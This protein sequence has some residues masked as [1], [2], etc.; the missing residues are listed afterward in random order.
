[1]IDLNNLMD[2]F[3]YYFKENDSYKVDGKGLLE[4]F[5][6]ICG[7]YFQQHPLADLD[8]FLE[9]LDVNKTNIIFVQNFWK[10]FGELPFAQGPVIDPE[11]FTKTFTGFNFDEAISKATRSTEPY[12]GKDSIDYR[13]IIKYA[14]SLFK[15][16]G[17]QQFFEIM[18]RLY[19]MNVTIVLPEGENPFLKDSTSRFDLEDSQYDKTT[20]DNY[21]RCQNCSEVTFQLG[22]PD[23]LKS[24]LQ[25]EILPYINQVKS[26]IERFVPFYITPVIK[27]TG[28]STFNQVKIEVSSD[29]MTLQPGET[30]SVTVK[31]SPIVPGNSLVPLTYRVAVVDYGK[32]PTDDDYSIQEY[33]D[34]TY[35]IYLGNK[36]YWFKPVADLVAGAKPVKVDVV[37]EYTNSQYMIWV[38]SPAANQR[39]L[40]KK[41]TTIDIKVQAVENVFT[42][43]NGAL[44]RQVQ[45]KPA[46]L[47]EDTGEVFENG[48]ANAT[49]DYYGYQT[50]SIYNYRT[51]KARIYIDIT[52]EYKA[53]LDI[54]TLTFDPPYLLIKDNSFAE[55][56]S[57]G[58]ID[59]LGAGVYG[60]QD[61]INWTPHNFSTVFKVTDREGNPQPTAQIFESQ[62]AT[63]VYHDGDTFVPYASGAADYTFYAKVGDKESEK[64]VFSVMNDVAITP[65]IKSLIVTPNPLEF[66]VSSGAQVK[67]LYGEVRVSGLNRNQAKNW[68]PEIIMEVPGNSPQTIHCTYDKF[69]S[70][71]AVYKFTATH[72]E[73]A[74][75]DPYNITFYANTSTKTPKQTVTVNTYQSTVKF[76]IEPSKAQISQWSGIN[77]SDSTLNNNLTFTAK[78][79][80]SIAKFTFEGNVTG[81]ITGSNGQ[82]YSVSDDPDQVVEIEVNGNQDLTFTADGATVT[83]HLKDFAANVSIRC[84]P[85][86]AT[87]TAEKPEVSTVITG[88]TNKNDKFRFKID[89]E[90]TIYTIDPNSNV[91]QY[92]FRTASPGTH[93]FTAVDD[94]LKVAT[95]EVNS[96]LITDIQVTPN[97]LTWEASDTNPKTFEIQL[98]STA[99][100]TIT[101]ED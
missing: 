62:N 80:S 61:D 74:V 70:N 6:N 82:T 15:I 88:S 41:K 28:Q 30:S 9:N 64:S 81:V 31:V 68:S 95:F 72:T 13:S 33:S 2:L 29:G 92:E 69:E 53:E 65:I 94:P 91:P 24:A 87:I 11:I 46:I 52:P 14:I 49:V 16:R 57:S 37:E 25:S 54:L 55:G 66:Q 73:S 42:Y 89:D 48:E 101:E 47:W 32:N 36:T 19:G 26:F 100:V 45:N 20:F 22:I 4:R 8:S 21:Y 12:T 10:F 96:T 40:S 99:T 7:N 5:L 85:T 50:F 56:T 97:S 79:G 75:K 39:V 58:T 78:P 59:K 44:V 83:L 71:I 90:E 34:S 51:R 3:P 93:T 43:Q 77:S 98:P 60:S 1:M 76:Y 17:T 38:V 18:F 84:N 35:N 23:S 27:V 67:S 63:K 86:K